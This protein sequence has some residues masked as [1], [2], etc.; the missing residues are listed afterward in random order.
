MDFLNL[1]MREVAMFDAII[2]D[3]PYGIRAMSK[4]SGKKEKLNSAKCSDS[5]DEKMQQPVD[6]D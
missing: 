5:K 1:P 3:P 4:Q 6:L 2:C